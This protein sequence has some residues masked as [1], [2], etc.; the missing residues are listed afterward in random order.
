MRG[1]LARPK[2]F[3]QQ[4]VVV[5]PLLIRFVLAKRFVLGMALPSP[6]PSPPVGERGECVAARCSNVDAGLWGET[7]MS[8]IGDA[9]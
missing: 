8:R 4:T 1:A 5:L 2:R 7:V 3:E 6:C 9:P